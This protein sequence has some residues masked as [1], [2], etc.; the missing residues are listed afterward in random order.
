VPIAN[1][2]IAKITKTF[3][4]QIA[5]PKL[6]RWI[7]V[8]VRTADGSS[9]PTSPTMHATT[10]NQGNLWG[11]TYLAGGAKPQQVGY[12][13]LALGALRR[14]VVGRSRI[15]S[16][17]AAMLATRLTF[18]AAGGAGF[19]NALSDAR[20]QWQLRIEFVAQSCR[21]TST[22]SSRCLTESPLGRQQLTSGLAEVI[23]LPAKAT[24]IVVDAMRL[25]G[26]QA[27]ESAELSH[28]FKPHRWF[29]FQSLQ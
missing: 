13:N 16:R 4:I 11:H 1:Q 10:S 8:A 5:S 3:G 25:A 7:K 24:A 19:G 21:I 6:L 14:I 27:K 17:V 2:F 15:A 20:T 26:N 18:D 9:L 28:Q 23:A 12:T 29:D 22:C